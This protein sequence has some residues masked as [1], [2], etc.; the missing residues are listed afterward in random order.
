MGGFTAVCDWTCRIHH[1]LYP[2]ISEI[3]SGAYKKWVQETWA[4]D[5]G[6]LYD[7]GGM[8]GGCEYVVDDV[9]ELENEWLHLM[10]ASVAVWCFCKCK[11]FVVSMEKNISVESCNMGDVDEVECVLYN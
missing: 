2:I 1:T 11:N 9:R 3:S 7:Y 10:A 6:R 4:C 8:Y 5:E